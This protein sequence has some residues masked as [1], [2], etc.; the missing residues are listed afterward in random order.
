MLFLAPLKEKINLAPLL[1]VCAFIL[2]EG[3]CG[4]SQRTKDCHKDKDPHCGLYQKDGKILEGEVQRHCQR[5]S[6]SV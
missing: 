2:Q 6:A 4:I 1:A 3:V 5:Q